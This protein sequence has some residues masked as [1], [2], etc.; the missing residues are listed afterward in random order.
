MKWNRN[1]YLGDNIKNKKT[2]TIIQLKMGK[3]CPGIYLLALPANDE[4]VLDIY[5]AMVVNQKYYRK[6]KQMIVGIAQGRDEAMIVM[7]SMIKDCY[8]KTGQ[9]KVKHMYNV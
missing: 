2:K 9:Y 4:N 6:S 8:E 1:L 7:Q 3:I 5:P